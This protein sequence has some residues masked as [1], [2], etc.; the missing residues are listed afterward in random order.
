MFEEVSEERLAPDEEYYCSEARSI[1]NA[2]RRASRA[3]CKPSVDCCTSKD[4]GE[5]RGM[6]AQECGLQVR[7]FDIV[8]SVEVERIV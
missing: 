1:L 7:Y 6:L 3:K 2:M 8:S 5:A 4:K